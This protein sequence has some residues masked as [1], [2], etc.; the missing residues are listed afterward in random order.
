MSNQ[1][2]NKKNKHILLK[3][4]ITASLL[5][6]PT[7]LTQTH[8]AHASENG[9][10]ITHDLSNHQQIKTKDILDKEKKQKI[11]GVD[12][13]KVNVAKEE[14]GDNIQNN[15]DNH[16]TYNEPFKYKDNFYEFGQGSSL[17][18]AMKALDME[19]NM[20]DKD[21]SSSQLKI[22]DNTNI[23][24]ITVPGKEKNVLGT[25]SAV[26]ISK[27]ALL[28]NNHVIRKDETKG[29]EHHDEKDINIYPQRDGDQIPYKLKPKKVDMLKSADASILYVDEDLSKMMDITPMAN[30]KDIENIKENSDISVQGYPTGKRHENQVKYPDQFGHAFD[31]K[32]K[33]LMNATSIHPVMYY[34]AYTESGMSGSPVLNKEGKLIG[35]HA[36][37]ID[38]NNGNNGDTSYGYT[39]TKNFR[40]DLIEKIPELDKKASTSKDTHD[41][42]KAT[43]ESKKD[44]D[45]KENQDEN[46]K[47][48]DNKTSKNDDNKSQDKEV[49]TP[50]KDVKNTSNKN[51]AKAA[52]TDQPKAEKD[53]SKS[54]DEDHAK[55]ENTDKKST[56]SNDDK[57]I[58]DNNSKSD[59]DEENEQPTENVSDKN[60]QKNETSS[61]SN[62][63][64]RAATQEQPS[65]T[66]TT[67][68]NN[69]NTQTDDHT[70]SDDTKQKDTTK[71]KK[72]A[73]HP[74]NDKNDE[75]SKDKDAKTHHSLGHIDK[76]K[77]EKTVAN[78]KSK[79]D[80]DKE[81]A[82]SEAKKD[83]DDDSSENP[84]E[85]PKK[86]EP[87]K[88]SPEATASSNHNQPTNDEKPEAEN[89]DN[90][91][92]NDIE[93][94]TS[95]EPEQPK[96]HQTFKG[97]PDTG[98][99]AGNVSLLAVTL[100]G[101]GGIAILGAQSLRKWRKNKIDDID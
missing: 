95:E 45:I 66:T 36:G 25:G 54:D 10:E 14:T 92:P 44:D 101:V 41:K 76:D 31:A 35:I 77:E 58:T 74:S 24:N 83:D 8:D 22:K 55:D 32:S 90:Q 88:E 3:S 51:E 6:T 84:K 79:N 75:K 48:N 4:T 71:S 89:K 70:D 1:Q 20:P 53:Q 52:E 65:E 47:E 73:D 98:S 38:S 59:G 43:S 62:T 63:S 21:I 34:K 30:E 78:S 93:Q 82:T 19:K 91:A 2:S 17:S 33:F 72:E 40:K 27:H 12:N 15:T 16:G 80:N 69:N 37:V 39:F 56:Q 13:K 11:E 5:L 9:K 94:A 29:F 67:S 68:S 50:S 46:K 26:A 97:L 18:G 23:A 61:D 57:E 28:T 86:E 81:Q 87:K 49:I 42:E 99:T 85:A 60:N 100:T 7:A 96:D 64:N